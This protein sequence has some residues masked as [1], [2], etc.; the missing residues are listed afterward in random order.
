MQN[1]AVTDETPS[2]TSVNLPSKESR[3]TYRKVAAHRIVATRTM[4]HTGDHENA[5]HWR[6]FSL[7]TSGDP[8]IIG[9]LLSI[10]RGPAGGEEAT[11]ALRAICLSP[12]VAPIR[13]MFVL[14]RED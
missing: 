11:V 4:P 1:I 3:G 5:C 12:N 6:A 2:R 9:P 10:S 13:A 7:L 14:H 8:P